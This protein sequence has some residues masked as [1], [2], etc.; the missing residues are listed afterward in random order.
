MSQ[1]RAGESCTCRCHL[2]D[3]ALGEE[4]GAPL[5]A[6][7]LHGCWW[8]NGCPQIPQRK[9]PHSLGDVPLWWCPFPTHQPSHA[10]QQPHPPYQG[11][12]ATKQSV[13][14]VKRPKSLQTYIGV[15]MCAHNKEESVKVPKMQLLYFV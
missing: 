8:P 15:L 5:R 3:E 10:T 11:K 7:Q 13:Q 12:V 9:A 6:S 1:L 4:E 14:L 2:P